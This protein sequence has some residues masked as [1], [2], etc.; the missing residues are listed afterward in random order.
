MRFITI[1]KPG[2][3]FGNAITVTGAYFLG[4]QGHVFFW[5][6]LITLLAMSLV[7]ASGCVLN[8]YID[9]DID[10]LMERTK[11]RPTALGLVTGPVAI[12]YAI[13]LGTA[14]LLTLYW[15]I[16][17]LTAMVAL[18]GLCVYVFIYSLYSKRNSAYGTAIGG[19]AG[20]IPPVVGYCAATNEFDSGAVILFLILF[21]WQIPHSYAI[22]IYRL[23]DYAAASIPV[24]PVRKNIQAAKKSILWHVIG[25]AIVCL[26][27]SLLGYTGWIYFIAALMVGAVW[28]YFSIQGFRAEDDAVWAR[29]MFLMSIINITVLSVAMS[30]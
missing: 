28:L 17:P 7:I 18:F 22:A 11:N 16:N 15:F 10:K 29:K 14:G 6:F 21:F 25:F 27:L 2:I 26:S 4:S 19:I 30:I 12:S 5:H 8:N 3:I 20:A 23:K 9:R 1:T 13:V 24:L